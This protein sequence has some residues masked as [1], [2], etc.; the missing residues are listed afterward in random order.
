MRGW[1]VTINSSYFRTLVWSRG[2]TTKNL[3]SAMSTSTTPAAKEKETSASADKQFSNTLK[4]PKTAFPLRAGGTAYEEAWREKT[5]QE[6]Y[7]WQVCQN[8]RDEELC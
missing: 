3:R 8:L 6:L 4:L 2:H 1:Q 7:A 5:T